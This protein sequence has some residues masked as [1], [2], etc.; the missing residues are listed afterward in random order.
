MQRYLFLFYFTIFSLTSFSQNE[1]SGTV[2]DAK[3]NE[4]IIGA[5]VY[6]PGGNGTITNVSGKY[7][8]KFK[9]ND[10]TIVCSFIG[11]LPDTL[12]KQRGTIQQDFYLK[13]NSEELETVVV[14]AGRYEQN[15]EKVTVSMQVIKPEFLENKGVVDIEEI[16]N[17]IPGVRVSDGQVSIRGGSGFS[18]GAGSRVLL[19]L[20][21]MPL[22]SADAGDIKWN[23][24]PLE[25]I[26]QIEVIKGASSVLYGSSAMNGVINLRTQFPGDKPETKIRTV[27]G[28]YGDPKREEIKWWSFNPIYTGLDFSHSRIIKNNTDLIVGGSIYADEGYRQGASEMRGRVNAQVRHRSKRIEGLTFG[29]NTS[30]QTQRQALFLVWQA[31]TMPYVPAGGGN[32]LD[33][34][35]SLSYVDGIR[36]N[37][38][39]YVEYRDNNGNRHSLRT[40]WYRVNNRGTEQTSALSDLFFGEYQYQK[41]FNDHFIL[42]SGVASFANGVKSNLYGDHQG[43]NV[44][45]F[46]Q[47]DATI[48]KKLTL[49]GGLRFEYYQLDTAKSSNYEIMTKNDTISIPVQPVFRFGANYEIFKHTHIRASW[50][51]GY[52]Y[53]S[54]S[55]RYVATNVGAL[56]IFPNPNLQPEKGWTAEVGLQQRFKIL[57]WV[58]SVDV[59]GFWMEYDNMIEFAFDYFLADSINPSLDPA[60]DNYLFNWLGFQ[61]RNAE[62][63]RITGGEITIQGAGKLGPID[64]TIIGGYTYMNPITLNT[65]SAYLATFSD[66]TTNMLKYR[67]NHLAKMDIQLSYKGFFIGGSARYNSYMR[68]IDATFE[69]VYIEVNNFPIQGD[70]LLPGLKEYR[71]ERQNGDL[72]FDGRVGYQFNKNASISFIVNNFL[73]REYMSRPGDVQAPRTYVVQGVFRF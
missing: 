57:N 10:E 6:I 50:G 19:T 8:L 11:Y 2:Y 61:A 47:M 1:I 25:N 4:P 17:Q 42:T 72:V 70:F 35:S 40:R 34:A 14:S 65:D 39:P 56:N 54:I 26:G 9:K 29:L 18:Y 7:F 28:V 36:L 16:T 49:S 32:H 71:E 31:D 44:A 48:F 27:S 23:T 13:E 22:L 63:A 52:R 38:D 67:V 12:K 45:A 51:M 30:A 58:G 43:Y 24:L 69:G 46:S 55:E 60:D 41:R 68:N 73:N 3:T 53:P 15:L 66:T 62:N 33:S 59:A 20:D 5:S 37:V 64:M 21:E